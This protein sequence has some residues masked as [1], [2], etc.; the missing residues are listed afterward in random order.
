M[1]NIA[2]VKATGPDT[3][4]IMLKKPDAAF[5]V[6]SLSKLNLAPKHVW[7]PIFKS[8][9]GKP[10][11]AESIIEEHPVSSGPFRLV[12][13]KLNEEIVLE[14]NKDHWAAPK[15][16]RWIMRIEPNIEASLGAMRSGEIN[17]LADYT[18]DPQLLADLAKAS[19]D[20]KMAEALDMGFKFLAYNNRRPPFD[21]KA[22]RQALSALID[23]QAIAEDAFGGAAVPANSW[24]S[25][26]LAFW[27]DDGIEKRVPAL[28]I[29]RRRRRSWRM[30]ASCWSMAG[31][32]IRPG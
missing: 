5:L 32:T 29:W 1:R 30:P 13:T 12:K 19:P 18:G 24:V 8:L 10:E 16:D 11:T 14:A 4:T 6:S 28:G 3:L 27:H 7:E 25:P 22:F 9:E 20:I 2:S 17:F 21:S 26:A 23:R 31:C 15:V